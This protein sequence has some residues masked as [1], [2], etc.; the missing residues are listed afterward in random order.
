VI[1]LSDNVI[2][3]LPA[4]GP[5]FVGPPLQFAPTGAPIAIVN[6]PG[7]VRLSPFFYPARICI[8]HGGA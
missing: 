4:S 8:T 7:P 3:A 2:R 5:P 6:P 1:G